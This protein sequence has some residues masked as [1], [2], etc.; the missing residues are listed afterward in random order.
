MKTW[1]NQAAAGFSNVAVL[2]PNPPI[3]P[4]GRCYAEQGGKIVFRDTQHLT[5]GYTK[6]LANELA[7][8]MVEHGQRL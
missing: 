2:D 6:S 3:C 7:R 5:A 4:E 1:I 8:K